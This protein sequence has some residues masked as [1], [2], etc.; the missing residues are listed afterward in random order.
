MVKFRVDAVFPPHSITR[1]RSSPAGLPAAF[2]GFELRDREPEADSGASS[3]L[4][5]DDHFRSLGGQ[6]QECAIGRAGMLPGV[7][8]LLVPVYRLELY[9]LEML[10]LSGPVDK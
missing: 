3:V 10:G 2:Q 7:E 5:E 9:L 4:G 6:A 8:Q 1:A